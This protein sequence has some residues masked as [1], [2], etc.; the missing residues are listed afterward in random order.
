VITSPTNA[1][2]QWIRSLQRKRRARQQEGL[3]VVEGTRLGEE[4]LR[5][6]LLPALVVHA[7]DLDERSST[8]V[9]TFAR[10]G[11]PILSVS[12]RVMAACA[13]TENPQ[14]VLAVVPVPALPLPAPLTL[15]VVADGIS[16][17]GNLGTLLR[18]ARACGVEAMFLSPST[19]DA[20]NPKVVRSAMGAHFHV[21]LIHESDEEIVGRLGGLKA[22][23][24]EARGGLSYD[25]LAARDPLALVIG[26][27][28]HGPS[29]FGRSH[30]A[31]SVSIPLA[32]GVESLNAAIAAAVILFEVRR[33]R[34]SKD[35]V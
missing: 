25:Q 8:L 28:A 27:E 20:Y 6:G 16:D 31:G 19:V 1:R 24:A 11:A 12:E 35:S 5:A 4:A 29:A 34:E 9:H 30:A 2:V 7:P 10:R 17:P 22:W 33:Q 32:G 13:S 23:V 26:Q 3:F 15:A 21:P 14:G 18:T